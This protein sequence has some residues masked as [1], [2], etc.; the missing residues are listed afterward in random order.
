MISTPFTAISN[1]GT[2]KLN[3]HYVLLL[4][5]RSWFVLLLGKQFSENL[6]EG[7]GNNSD[8]VFENDCV[9]ANG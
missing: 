6:L 5:D 3:I 1:D 4:Q 9:E 7:F 2:Y 8:Q